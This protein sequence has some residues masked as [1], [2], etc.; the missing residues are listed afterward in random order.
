MEE[1]FKDIPGFE[2]QYQAGNLGTI[3]RIT[4]RRGRHMGAVSTDVLRHP[5][6]YVS[7]RLNGVQYLVH[8]LVAMAWIEGDFSLT[9]NHIDG[10]I[11]NNCVENLEWMTRGDNT[12]ESW[13]RKPPRRGTP[14]MRKRPELWE[15]KEEMLA[16]RAEGHSL[17][18]IA[19]HFKTSHLIIK[20][21][22]SK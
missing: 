8:R 14:A 4:P 17:R 21:I 19:R 16:M 5:A 11:T 3:I 1:Q 15:K 10:C 13:R 18:S 6:G 7:C 20:N 22:L 2:G 9:I 12:R